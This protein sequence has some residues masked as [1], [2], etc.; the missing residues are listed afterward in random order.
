MI[1]PIA[2]ERRRGRSL[3]G[4]QLLGGRQRR[5]EHTGG[6]ADVGPMQGH[7]HQRASLEIHR[8]FDLVGQM[9]PPIFE[10]R[11]LGVRVR[12][13]HPLRIGC[14]FLAPT[15]EPGQR[16]P[17][18]R[19]ETRGLGQ[20]GEELLI[21]FPGVPPHDAPHR[22]VRFQRRGIHGE[23]LAP[24]QMGGDQALLHPRKHG[25]VRLDI[26]QPSR[27]RDRRVIGRGLGQPQAQELADRQRVGGA[28]G[29]PTLR[30]ETFEVS[31]QQQPEVPA[32]G[33]TGSSH[34]GGVERPAVLF[35]KPVEAR[36]VENLVQSHIE[37]MARGQRQLGRGNPHRRLFALAF[38]HRHGSQCTILRASGDVLSSTFTTGC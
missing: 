6:V 14:P 13:I 12:R 27:A 29:D 22:G 10:L 5:R 4:R 8:V 32:G 30:V 21:A 15:V 24:E 11:D 3:H 2:D 34:H 7:G 19:P 37:R 26:D 23:R 18:R 20:P 38:A 9:R 36:G 25:L 33:K 31:D 17:A 16:F 1:A 35:N 28:P